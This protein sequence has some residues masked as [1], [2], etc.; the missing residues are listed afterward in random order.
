MPSPSTTSAI[1]L[2][3]LHVVL[4]VRMARLGWPFLLHVVVR[5]SPCTLRTSWL[6]LRY[7]RSLTLLLLGMRLACSRCRASCL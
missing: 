4:A 3:L 6:V 7:R 5:V 1:A 2:H